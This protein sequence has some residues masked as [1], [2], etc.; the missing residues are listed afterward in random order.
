[1]LNV[2]IKV[3][4]LTF[5]IIYPGLNQLNL[6]IWLR[7]DTNFWHF[8]YL[9]DT[10]IHMQRWAMKVQGVTENLYFPHN[11]AANHHSAKQV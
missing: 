8:M 6:T 11:N 4:R 10:K 3:N 9:I 5:K 2:N 1:M 7:K